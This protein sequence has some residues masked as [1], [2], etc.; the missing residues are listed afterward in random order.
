VRIS[1][2]EPPPIRWVIRVPGFQ[3]ASMVPVSRMVFSETTRMSAIFR[4][5]ADWTAGSS[6]AGIALRKLR[7]CMVP[8]PW[9]KV[10]HPAGD[11]GS[12]ATLFGDQAVAQ[13]DVA[14]GVNGLAVS[15]FIQALEVLVR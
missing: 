7:L 3:A 4:R 2:K 10:A 8:F 9:L 1:V 5:G 12:A 11:A 14:A 13:Q 15:L 6:A